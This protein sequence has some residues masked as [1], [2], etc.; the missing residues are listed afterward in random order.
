LILNSLCVLLRES[1]SL[2]HL[3]TYLIVNQ[4]N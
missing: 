2:R 4:G 1:P 3:T